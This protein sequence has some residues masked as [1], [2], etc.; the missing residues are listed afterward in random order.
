MTY[1]PLPSINVVIF[2][3]NHSPVY[4][5]ICVKAMH[6]WCKNTITLK[7]FN[8]CNIS[9]HM[10]V[11]T[12]WPF[13]LRQSSGQGATSAH[14][15]LQSALSWKLFKVSSQ[16]KLFFNQHHSQIPGIP[17]LWNYGHFTLYIGYTPQLQL[18][19]SS[20]HKTV[21]RRKTR[22][23]EWL[24][25]I[26]RRMYVIERVHAYSNSYMNVD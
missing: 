13:S 9:L 1:Y 16:L 14:T 8:S 2:I 15:C 11:Q 23:H 24:D 3:E 12:W 25:I 6:M 20:I 5:I 17:H 18:P 26:H 19:G 22:C 4:N 7:R 21:L 10:Y